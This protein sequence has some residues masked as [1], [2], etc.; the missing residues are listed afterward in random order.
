MQ[1][2]WDEKLAPKKKKKKIILLTTIIYAFD[3]DFD[4]YAVRICVTATF[5]KHVLL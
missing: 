3:I 1:M 5:H 2:K 4:Q